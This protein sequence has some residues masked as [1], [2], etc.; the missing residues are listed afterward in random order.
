LLIS[1]HFIHDFYFYYKDIPLFDC[2]I[3][4]R[5]SRATPKYNQPFYS[6]NS[7]LS[8]R[9]IFFSNLF[10]ITKQQECMKIKVNFKGFMLLALFTV[11]SNFAFAQRS[12]TGV[13]KDA[14]SGESLVGAS[15]V[16]SGTTKG[17]L[18]DLDGKYELQ[19]PADAASLTFSYTGYSNLTIALGA[20]KVVDANLK[21]G[22]ILEAVTV[23]GYGSV[24][25]KDAT[26]AVNTITE[27]DFNRGVINSPEQLMAGRVAGVQVTQA[28][29]EPGGGIN[30]RIRGTSSVRSGNNPLFVIDGVP[31]SGE[32][33]SAGGGGTSIGSS[34]P[35]NPLNFLN[36]DDIASID[37][38]KDA[39]ATAIYGSRGANGV[40]L[41]TTK[42]GKS[43]KGTLDYSYS[44]GSSTIAKRY[45]L[46]STAAFIA[47]TN[48]PTKPK[49]EKNLGGST[50]WQ[51]EVFRTATTHNHNLSFGSGDANGA[52]RFS[53]GYLNQD[54]IVKNSNVTRYNARFNADRK[55][56]DNKLKVG[57]QATVSNNLDNGVPISDNGGFEG[58]L[59]GDVLKANPTMPLYGYYDGK[60][61]GKD[62]LSQAGTSEPSPVALLTYSKDI[63]KTL[64]TLG[65]ITAEYQIMD[66][67]SFKTLVGFDRSASARKAAYSRDLVVAGIW[68]NGIVNTNDIAVNN[69]LVESYFNY[70]KQF[71]SVGFSG[72]LGYSYQQF[73]RSGNGTKSVGYR[74]GDLNLMINNS[75][76]LD[77]GASGKSV[78]TYSFNTI[79]ELQSYFGRLNFNISDKYVVTATLRADGST[80]FGGNNKYGYFPSFAAK[81]RVIEESFIPKNIFSDLGI[82]I[83]YGVTG[84]QEIPHNLYDA[85][86]RYNGFGINND[87]GI[88]GGGIGNVSFNNPDLQWETTSAINFG[89]DFGFMNNRVSGSLDIYDKNTTKL[90][91]QTTSAQPALAP[92]Q[93]S[94]LDAIVNNKGVELSLNVIAVTNK[95]FKWE[96]S[97]NLASNRNVVKNFTGLINTGAINGQGLTGAF[98][99]RIAQDQPLF[100]FFL[101]DFGGFDK[102]GNSIYPSGDFQQFLPGGGG[103]QSKS[104]LPTL[105]GA[106]S[107]SFRYK[108]LDVNFMFS[109]VTGNYI[110]SNTANAYFTKGSLSNG[111][112]VT[113]DVV[114]SLEGPLNA[115]DV[116]TRFLQDGSFLRLQNLSVGYNVKLNSTKVSSLRLSLTGQNLYTITGYTGQDPE[117]STNK[118]I[119]GV[120]S[121]GIDYTAYPRARTWT[122]G[123]AISF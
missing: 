106:F 91:I 97:G 37:I 30:V 12:V 61:A 36:P 17:T 44:L 74:T 27:K 88:E 66:G 29:G 83:G 113:T 19:V 107:N 96:I 24:K 64:R 69:S 119:N 109:G 93:W 68:K 18:T 75:T 123:A 94:N 80:K 3:D 15:V 58:D 77:A 92:F 108:D 6:Y 63:T 9:R 90:L 22:S 38:L 55:F 48:D 14:D 104:P 45:D 43:G 50:D 31:L 26:G 84:N 52:Y 102:D 117:V 21:G 110:Y 40:V 78:P 7:E 11:L 54:G 118:A 59:L 122:V 120:P 100:A 116:S 46:L 57:V 105:T 23:V 112:N 33:T 51:N 82:R 20:S 85:R 81:W 70:T 56:L 73:D 28:S 39:S 16:V 49:N 4:K 71:G 42:S 86:N 53:L 1:R 62:T 10:F 111:R 89:I 67:L 103:G 87:K 79:D 25:K 76:T 34:T 101:R 99:Q 32:E 35:K 13:V 121:F 47:A 60:A 115:P 114:S 41:I 95:D 98:A 72:L 2:I 65:N 5:L 8:P